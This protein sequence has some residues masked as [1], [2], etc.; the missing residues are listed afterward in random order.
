MLY[1]HWSLNNPQPSSVPINV[2][3]KNTSWRRVYTYNLRWFQLNFALMIGIYVGYNI[4]CTTHDKYYVVG[5][6]LFLSQYIVILEVIYFKT[7]IF[8]LISFSSHLGIT[9]MHI[10][11]NDLIYTLDTILSDTVSV[12]DTDLCNCRYYFQWDYELDR[13]RINMVMFCVPFEYTKRRN[14]GQ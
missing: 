11:N 13:V 2:F 4:T 14:N 6:Y 8:Q 3:S 1:Y 7:F 5:T 12:S 10:T 9:I